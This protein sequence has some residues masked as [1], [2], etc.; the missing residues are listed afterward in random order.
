[1]KVS[2]IVENSNGNIFKTPPF[3]YEEVELKEMIEVVRNFKSLDYL[4]LETEE[5]FTYFNPKHIVNVTIIKE[6]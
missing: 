5:G 1:M 4:V 6:N 2:F 3:P